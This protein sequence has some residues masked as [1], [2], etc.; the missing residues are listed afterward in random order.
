[1]WLN[2]CKAGIDLSLRRIKKFKKEWKQNFKAIHVG[3]TNGKGSVC[4]FIAGV[5]SRKY[6]VGLYTSPHL[7]RVNERIRINGVEISDEE[8]KKYSYL[9]KY[10]FTYFEA[11]TALALKYFEEHGVDYAVIEVGMGGRL[12]A[13]NIV[14]AEITIITNVDME[15]TQW[16]GKSVEKIAMEKAGIIKG[17]SVI[18][19]CKGKALEVI[20]KVA[21]EKGAE[22]YVEGEHFKWNC[23]NNGFL[24]EADEKYFIKPKMNA[25]YQGSNISMAI[26]ALELLDMEKD[27]IIDGIESV[28]IPARMEKIDRFIID[29]AHNPA[30][31]QAFV[32]ALE[33]MGEKPVIIFG[34]M[35]DKDVKKMIELLQKISDK[36]IVT[37]AKNARAMEP[38]KIARFC[39]KAIVAKS[40]EEA[41]EIAEE[42]G[43]KIAIV[44][45]LYLAGEARSYIKSKIKSGK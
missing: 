26:K 3:G 8:I 4:N 25:L 30:A 44:G 29:G 39:R 9:C 12:D 43:N 13:T 21:K 37:K 18:T 20:K 36:I 32:T 16:L 28:V 31:V 45:S 6:K 34:A 2:D 33:R 10:G 35:K 7:G 15:H 5:L 14:D 27:A 40:I 22:L 41:I 24:I 17:S 1:M 23:H 11:L 19:A 42:T 38:E